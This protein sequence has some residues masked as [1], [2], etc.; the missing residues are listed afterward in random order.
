M[1]GS[2]GQAMG[3]ACRGGFGGSG[4]DGGSGGG[5][6]G[7]HSVAFAFVGGA[8]PDLSSTTIVLGTPGVGGAG[9]DMDMSTQ[10]QGDRGLPC[11]ALDF[12]APVSASCEGGA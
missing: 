2:P 5:G 6:A 7:G 1:G 4:G 3:N 10:T 8:L 11:M 12:S 9:G